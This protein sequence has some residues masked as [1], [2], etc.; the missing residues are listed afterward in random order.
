VSPLTQGL[1]YRA[2]RDGLADQAC[3]LSFESIFLSEGHDE[4]KMRLLPNLESG[5]PSTIVQYHHQ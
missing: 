1:R 3:T 5:T 2:A 4:L